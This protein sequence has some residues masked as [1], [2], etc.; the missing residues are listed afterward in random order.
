MTKRFR[1]GLCTCSYGIRTQGSCFSSFDLPEGKVE[2][3]AAEN[4]LVFGGC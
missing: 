4:A 1:S 2:D 3:F